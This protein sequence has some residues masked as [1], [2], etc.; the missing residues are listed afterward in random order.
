MSVDDN[1]VSFDNSQL[2]DSDS[3]LSFVTF[4]PNQ[5]LEKK[6]R[7]K[8][9]K[10]KGYN[11][12]I[13]K[14]KDE[15]KYFLEDGTPVTYNDKTIKYYISTR[16]CGIGPITRCE[17]DKKDLFKYPYEWNPYTGKVREINGQKKKDDYG[18]LHFSATALCYHFFCKRLDYLWTDGQETDDGYFEGHYGDGLGAG[19]NFFV[20]S[21]GSH[22]EWYIFRLPI[23]DCYLTSNHN[24]K[25]ITYGPKLTD[26]EIKEIY[27]TAKKADLF[28]KIFGFSLPDIVKMKYWYD[29]AISKNP[30]NVIISSDMTKKQIM[31]VKEKANKKAVEVLRKFQ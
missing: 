28:Y 9:K 15:I 4:T 17:V 21:R 6:T 13:K 29:N 3:L 11:Q 12:L 7:K 30:M 19:E 10:N 5:N 25:Y 1:F 23:N 8:N 16:K 2:D 14:K 20:Q 26:E 27:E 22:P 31:D 24:K 18:P